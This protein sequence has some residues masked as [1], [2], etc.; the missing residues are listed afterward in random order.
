M[1]KTIKNKA[2]KPKGVK[3]KGVKSKPQKPK[4]AQ[5]APV[6]E[7]IKVTIAALDSEGIGLASHEDKTALVQG[8]FPGETVVAEVEHI[9]KTH[10]YSRL[11]RV[12]RN[13]PARTANPPCKIEQKCLGCSLVAMKYPAQLDY[14]HS[15]VAAAFAE[16]GLSADIAIEA[17]MPS[18]DPTHYRASAKLVFGRKREKIL[19]G[20]YQRGSHEVVDCPDCP[21]HHPLI[22]KI[23]AIVREEVSR[24]RIPVFSPQHQNG[25]LR[26]L[27]V[28]VSPASDKALVTFVCNYEDHQHL[29]KLAKWLMKK[30]PEVIGVHQNINSS[31]GNVII[32]QET[33]KVY[34]LPDLIDQV[35]DIKLRMSPESFF[36]VNTVQAAHIYALVRKWARLNKQDSAID[37]FCGI[38]GIALHLAQDAEYVTGIEYVPEAVRNAAENA[39][40]NQL[41]NCRFLSGDAAIE[42]QKVAA[43]IRKLKLVTVNPPRK[44]CSEELLA[45]LGHV[46]PEQIIYVSC[47]P[48]SLARDLASLTKNGYR[49]TK[50]QPVDMFPQTAH[51]ETVVH[52]QRG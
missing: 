43:G 18:P 16:H 52:L 39:R 42:F 37:L 19:L 17:V 25:L 38:G 51:I 2:V 36:Q 49:V 47:D 45:A 9:G 28:R 41:N 23:A 4:A 20:L 11:A 32:G 27:L 6:K 21:V 46:A 15:R 35:G 14:K 33:R 50:V 5:Q 8:A 1:R 48:D 29:P 24:Q 44:G 13:A 30:A 3:A 12:L 34:G 7:T 10:I 40:F 26:Y 31:A 22:N